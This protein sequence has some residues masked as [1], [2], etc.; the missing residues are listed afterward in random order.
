MDVHRMRSRMPSVRG[1]QLWISRAMCPCLDYLRVR[2]RY[3]FTSTVAFMKCGGLKSKSNRS[4]PS[5][6]ADSFPIEKYRLVT[7]CTHQPQYVDPLFLRTTGHG[8]EDFYYVVVSG[9]A[10]PV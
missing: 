2:C 10:V 6:C 3:H 8:P 9:S 5:S 4:L 1:S 7:K